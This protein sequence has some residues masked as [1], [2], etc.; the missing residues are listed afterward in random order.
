M[1][2]ECG[3]HESKEIHFLEEF[4][5]ISFRLILSKILYY[6]PEVLNKQALKFNVEDTQYDDWERRYL[7]LC[8]ILGKHNKLVHKEWPGFPLEINGKGAMEVD[9]NDLNVQAVVKRFT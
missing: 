4:E 7:G 5:E 1:C 3:E 8:M 2:C 6:Y 9:F